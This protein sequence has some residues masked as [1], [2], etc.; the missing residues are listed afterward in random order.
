ME[1]ILLINISGPDRPGVTAALMRILAH[2]QVTVLDIGQA[3]IHE[4]LSLGLLIQLT[5]H[6]EVSP[7]L[8][9]VLREMDEWGMQAQLRPVTSQRYEDWVSHQGKPRHILTVLARKVTARHIAEV[10][11]IAA[12]HGLNI[13]QLSRLSGRI[14]L[15]DSRERSSACVE[16]SVRGDLNEATR[17]AFL[18]V[19]RE[20]E[21]DIAVQRDD[22]FRRTR[23]LVA[24]DM[25]STL[26]QTEV[27][28]ELAAEAGA[29]EQ[30]AAITEA[31]M[32][33]EIDFQE[34][35]RQR[36]SV[37]KG[38]PESVLAKVAARLPLTEGAERLTRT[39]KALGYKTA[40]LSGGFTYFGR[41]LQTLFGI[42]FV[43]ANELEIV[44]GKLTGR[45]Q[46][47]IVDAE[48]KAALLKEIAEREGLRLEQ[49]IAVGDGANDLRMLG[50][51]GL[52][53]A[54]HAKPVVRENADQSISALGLD[55]LLYLIGMR[56]R[57]Q[58][59][60][61]AVS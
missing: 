31:A 42:D 29:G 7:M 25:D 54:F 46:G 18:R 48:R 35:L 36:V 22:A 11:A 26:I 17:K 47:P 56:E 39:L 14:H 23:R 5:E 28:D 38:L 58:E 44:D 51:A 53:I 2:R 60:L 59:H 27:I 52:G 21:I 43:H 15:N 8:L 55:G 50:A 3:V 16:L 4:N 41:H 13:D 6:S 12:G 33:G 19:G 40:I 24:F 57:D 61:D 10:A 9:E 49:T 20:L 32:R 30:V 1:D 34:S 37:L 45:V